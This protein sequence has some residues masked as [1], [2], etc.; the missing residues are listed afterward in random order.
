MTERLRILLIDDHTLFRES[1]VRLLET[2]PG[3]EV[4]ARCATVA[5]G[6]QAL[7]SSW[8]APNRRTNN[9]RCSNFGREVGRTSREARYL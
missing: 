2:E 7:A 6:Q 1:L 3:F 5:E 4:V 9:Q 8:P